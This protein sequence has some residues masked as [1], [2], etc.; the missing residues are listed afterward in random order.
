MNLFAIKIIATLC[1]V[2]DHVGLF[3]F[4][5][6]LWFRA[7]GRIAYPLFAFTVANAFVHTRSKGKYL[8]RML[9]LAVLIQIPYYAFL[10][11]TTLNIFFS[12]GLGFAFIWLYEAATKN[13][14]ERAAAGLL[15]AAAVFIAAEWGE[16]S[17]LPLQYGGYGL[18]LIFCCHLFYQKP[19]ALGAA[20]LLLLTAAAAADIFLLRADTAWAL[21]SF[22]S[23][24]A[25]PFLFAYNGEKGP[26]L[27]YF[28]YFFYPLH[29]VFLQCLAL[30]L[31]NG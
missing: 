24:L 3:F 9:L 26:G 16:Q 19:A 11:D 23:L 1:M 31:Q 13:H 2:V 12:L 22:C 28:F 30:L 15:L 7:I 14:R 4:P 21:L 29:L 18:A 10:R 20:Q 5:D 6:T 25:L 27:K 8:V 17:I